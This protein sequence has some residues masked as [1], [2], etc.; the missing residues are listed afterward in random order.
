MTK[1]RYEWDKTLE[2]GHEMIDS[3]H[4]QLFAAINDLLAKCEEGKGTDELGKSLDFL[5]DYTIK[6][7]F[8]EEKLQQKYNYPD[9]PNHKQYHEGFKK[10]VRDLKVQLIMKGPTAELLQEVHSK[11]GDWLVSHIKVQDSKLAAHIKAAG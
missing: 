2:T 4:K 6:H 11:I 10:T 3:Q 9:Y 7:F 8:D 5:N 1:M